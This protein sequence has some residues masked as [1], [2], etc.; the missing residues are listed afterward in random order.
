MTVFPLW[1]W[2]LASWAHLWLPNFQI[3]SSYIWSVSVFLFKVWDAFH[4]Y[5]LVRLWE[6]F[7]QG[8][9]PAPTFRSLRLEVCC[10]RD[11]SPIF[12]FQGPGLERSSCREL[13]PGTSFQNHELERRC[14]KG[15]SPGLASRVEG[16]CCRAMEC[17][18]KT[19]LKILYG[20]CSA[21]GVPSLFRGIVPT[22]GLGL[23]VISNIYESVKSRIGFH[24]DFV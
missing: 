24:S 12:S 11:L 18:V 5:E 8:Y 21:W 2:D 3:E 1:V 22:V 23:Q 13:S 20:Y 9:P 4:C 16:S 19:L 14:Y 10:C 15:I 17:G 6:A 7:A